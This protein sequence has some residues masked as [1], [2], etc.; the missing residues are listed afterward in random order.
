[1]SAPIWSR[2]NMALSLK[3]QGRGILPLCNI[4]LM[5]DT[6]VIRSLVTL[7]SSCRSH[8]NLE[9]AKQ[10]TTQEK[11]SRSTREANLTMA[12]GVQ[13]FKGKGSYACGMA[14]SAVCSSTPCPC[15]Q[16]D[17]KPGA[18][19]RALQKR[20]PSLRWAGP[21]NPQASCC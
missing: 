6:R 11:K 16:R 9:F 4:L 20:K 21:T 2:E 3:N 15:F 5:G 10:R 8:W 1:M 18:F 13:Y 19:I 14:V 7:F 12:T 17:C